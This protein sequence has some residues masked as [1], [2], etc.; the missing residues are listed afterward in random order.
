MKLFGKKNTTTTNKKDDNQIDIMEMIVIFR[1]EQSKNYDADIDDDIDQ[2]RMLEQR[3][4]RL[5]RRCRNRSDSNIVKNKN[6]DQ[7]K[8]P[9]S[10]DSE[11]ENV[12]QQIK[13]TKDPAEY[14]ETTSQFEA[15]IGDENEISREFHW[16]DHF[17]NETHHDD[18]I[19]WR[20][21]PCSINQW[22]MQYVDYAMDFPNFDDIQN[23]L[24]SIDHKS[25]ASSVM[26]IDGDQKI[27][28]N[29]FVDDSGDF[30]DHKVISFYSNTESS[31]YDADNDEA[32]DPKPLLSRRRYKTPKSTKKVND[33]RSSINWRKR[34]IFRI[35]L[36]VP[37]IF[38]P[39]VIVIQNNLDDT[40]VA[41]D[42]DEFIII[43]DPADYAE[44]TS[45]FELRVG[46]SESE[47]AQ[48]FRWLENYTDRTN[49][50]SIPV[51][52]RSS[53][54]NL[55]NFSP[56]DDQESISKPK[57]ERFWA[58]KLNDE[59]QS[60]E[61]K[62]I[63]MNELPV[64]ESEKDHHNLAMVKKEPPNWRRLKCLRSM[65]CVGRKNQTPPP[66][67]NKKN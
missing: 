12:P 18:E 64:E 39:M 52:W 26:A 20:S 55:E 23:T 10:D 14:A 57:L 63:P 38:T 45:Q 43:N 1:T 25:Q 27:Q 28:N 9:C 58:S 21:S 36:L 65:C 35:P 7:K 49:L 30:A 32:Y 8:D 24:D 16:L 22:P 15:R 3:I 50:R 5:T 11:N 53:L 44:T 59:T 33:D 13:I 56:L 42:L 60:D 31:D 19:Q 62:N 47:I 54:Q 48:E 61:I 66:S 6:T 46:S 51:E 37:L 29:N 34:D 67:P 17:T 2:Q 4:R 40:D 41:K